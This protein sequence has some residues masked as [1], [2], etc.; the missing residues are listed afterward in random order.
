MLVAPAIG[1]IVGSGTAGKLI[2]TAGP[3]I[4][5]LAMVGTC[6]APIVVLTGIIETTNAGLIALIL[7]FLRRRRRTGDAG[8]EGTKAHRQQAL[9]RRRLRA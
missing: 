9:V 6:A 3:R 2:H 4:L 1:M 8:P 5:S 7:G